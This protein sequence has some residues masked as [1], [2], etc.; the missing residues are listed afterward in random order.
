L[1]GTLKCQPAYGPVEVH[2]K[3]SFR[4]KRAVRAQQVALD[5]TYKSKARKI[6][7]E[8]IVLAGA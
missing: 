5:G 2:T 7:E 8:R 1:A 3:A 6:A 4:P